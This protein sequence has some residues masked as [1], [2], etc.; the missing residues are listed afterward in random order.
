VVE[1]LAL[2]RPPPRIAKVH[3][4]VKVI[5]GA[6]GWRAPSYQSVRRIIQGLDRGLLAMAH[7]DP[8]VYRDEFELVLR[9]ESIG[10]NDAVLPNR[11]PA[12]T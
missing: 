11:C 10:G 9:R 5:A 4:A 8:D 6:Q 12:T 7:H 2:R 1:G 3:R